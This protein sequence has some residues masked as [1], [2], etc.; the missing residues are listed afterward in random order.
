MAEEAELEINLSELAAVSKLYKHVTHSATSRYLRVEP[1][2]TNQ[3]GLD[4][5]KQALEDIYNNSSS[6][7]V[8]HISAG[9]SLNLAATGAKANGGVSTTGTITVCL[10]VTNTTSAESDTAKRNT[11]RTRSAQKK[12][13]GRDA[14]AVLPESVVASTVAMASISFALAS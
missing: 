6:F 12:L 1:Y 13:A 11:L 3:Y 9:E 5:P 8:T 10:A 7:D 2:H 4:T 14:S